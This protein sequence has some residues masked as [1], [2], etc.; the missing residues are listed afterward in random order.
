MMAA[1][2]GRVAVAGGPGCTC[3]ARTAARSRPPRASSSAEAVQQNILRL[4]EAGG[5]ASVFDGK[6]MGF[7][8]SA[9]QGT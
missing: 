5:V 7:S 1:T 9:S 3:A 8:R 2:S 6:V 4:G